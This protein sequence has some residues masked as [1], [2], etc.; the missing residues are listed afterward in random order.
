MLFALLIIN[1]SGGLIYNKDFG[2]GIAK[3]TSNEYLV[4]A[5]TIHSIHAIAT[6]ISPVAKSSGIETIESDNYKIHCFQTQTGLKFVVVA[7]ALAEKLDL[8]CQKIYELYADYAMKNPFFTPE[9]PIRAELFDLNVTR[10]IQT[11]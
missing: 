3:L 8:V 6:Q 1:K 9:M 4:L 10:L 7:D 11:L 2:N 5:G